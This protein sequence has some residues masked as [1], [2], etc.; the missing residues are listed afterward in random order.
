MLECGYFSL[1]TN[2]QASFAYTPICTFGDENYLY[3][4]LFDTMSE[5]RKI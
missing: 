1:L 4:P 5:K 3:S 2:P